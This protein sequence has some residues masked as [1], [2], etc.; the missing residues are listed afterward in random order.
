MGEG[1]YRSTRAQ[2]SF[3]HSPIYSLI[4]GTQVVIVLSSDI[5]VRELLDKRSVIYSSRPPLYLKQGVASGDL[6]FSLMVG[7]LRKVRFDHAKGY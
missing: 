1:P 6:R 5:V 4:I 7:I 2:D 3:K